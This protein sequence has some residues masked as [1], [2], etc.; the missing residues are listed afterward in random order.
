MALPE[1]LVVCSGCCR[2][3]WKS[4]VSNLWT[5]TGCFHL[6]HQ[7]VSCEKMSHL[8]LMP[9][10]VLWPG[11]TSDCTE[12][13]LLD[14]LSRGKTVALVLPIIAVQP[15]SKTETAQQKSNPSSF[16]PLQPTKVDR[17]GDNVAWI[18]V[19]RPENIVICTWNSCTGCLFLPCQPFA[20]GE[21]LPFSTI[22]MALFLL[23]R[24]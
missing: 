22:R 9:P 1:T 16:L 12:Q 6:T 19:I 10:P 18:W 15:H 14:P 13:L 23:R 3:S 20:K 5:R 8:S 7:P 21:K 24:E 17:L 2:Q 11:T 4:L